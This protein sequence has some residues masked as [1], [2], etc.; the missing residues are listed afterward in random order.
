MTNLDTE[1]STPAVTTAFGSA[2]ENGDDAHSAGIGDNQ[3]VRDFLAT[4]RKLGREEGKSGPARLNAL[5]APMDAIWDGSI[6]FKAG[7]K[8]PKK[9]AVNEED[10]VAEGFEAY[11]KAV[12]DAG[13]NMTSP[14]QQLSKFRA[15][16]AW[17]SGPDSWDVKTVRDAALK[18]Q[19]ELHDANKDIKKKSEQNKI[20]A[21]S[22]VLIN[23]AHKQMADGRM[24]N[25]DL[26]NEPLT[27]QEVDACIYRPD[28]A[29]K[30]L[31]DYC[32]TVIKRLN[33]YA[34]GVDEETGEKLVAANEQI[35]ALR[36]FLNQQAKAAQ[37]AEENL[38]A[39]NLLRSRGII[40]AGERP[41]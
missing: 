1:V 29:D 8:G 5:L 28:R 38:Q 18:K 2:D 41:F 20:Y 25:P 34:D 37:E 19:Q 3:A 32:D 24:A 12:V 22:Q 16:A 33:D 30:E 21:P 14:S 27:E 9:G 17:A 13:K 26:K 23:L 39:Y 11:R 36:D 6:V 4:M 15:V 40:M 35:T 7:K 31:V 10:H